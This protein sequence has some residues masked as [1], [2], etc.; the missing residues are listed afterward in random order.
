MII[1]LFFYRHPQTKPCTKAIK[2]VD[3]L[4]ATTPQPTAI[5]FNWTRFKDRP[6]EMSVLGQPVSINGKVYMTGWS[7]R[8]QTVLV[9]TRSG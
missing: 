5:T 9:Y 6:E 7:N 8:T 3:L 1:F 4:P 2:I